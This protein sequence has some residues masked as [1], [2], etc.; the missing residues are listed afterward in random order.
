MLFISPVKL[1]SFS[2]YLSFCI[3]FLVIYQNGLIK[4]IRIISNFMMSQPA[5]QTIVTHILPKISKSKGNQ[6]MKFGQLIECNL[7]CIFLDK[8][9]SKCDGKTSPRPFSEKLILSTS[10]D[11]WF[12]VL[13]CLLLLYGKLRA[14]EI[15]WNYVA[16]H[17]PSPRIKLFQKIKGGL[18][19]VSLPYFLHN[20]WRKIFLWPINQI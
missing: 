18:G 4:K 3:S 6:T 12:K 13:Y 15:Y 10:L 19:L 8:S 14:I 16:D 11:P 20:F 5:Q 7:R 17:L 9:Y 1:F 2:R